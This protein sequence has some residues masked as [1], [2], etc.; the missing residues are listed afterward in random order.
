MHRK[1]SFRCPMARSLHC[2]RWLG[3]GFSTTR[4]LINRAEW[5]IAYSTDF[6]GEWRK[7]DLPQMAGKIL[8]RRGATIE[9]AGLCGLIISEARHLGIQARKGGARPSKRQCFKM[10]SLYCSIRQNT[11]QHCTVRYVRKKSVSL[12]LCRCYLYFPFAAIWIEV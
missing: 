9:R 4:R 6:F 5:E 1:A 2:P 3:G 7:A 11:S 12:T 8:W 10:W